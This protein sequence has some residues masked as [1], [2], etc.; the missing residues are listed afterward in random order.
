MTSADFQHNFALSATQF[1]ERCLTLMVVLGATDEQVQKVEDLLRNADDALGHPLL[2]LGLCAELLLQHMQDIVEDAVDK[3]IETTRTMRPQSLSIG[4]VPS[5]NQ[6][7]SFMDRVQRNRRRS[8]QIEDEVKLTKA[9]LTK[10]LPK[11]AVTDGNLE[12]REIDE[13]TERFYERFEYIFL[14]MDALMS[15]SKIYADEMSFNAETIRGEIS[16]REA[17]S[18]AR[19]AGASVVIAVVATFYLPITSIATIFAMPVFDFKNDW[20]DWR[21]KPVPSTKS[22]N[23]STTG[24]DRKPAEELPVFSGYFWIYAAIAIGTMFFTFFLCWMFIGGTS[25]DD[26]DGTKHPFRRHMRNI[27]DFIME[28]VPYFIESCAKNRH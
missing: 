21:Y 3:C 18:G 13:V 16:R 8:Q 23:S 5:T 6:V 28:S 19:L 25:A 17:I 24:E 26:P 20:R 10:Q 27:F 11:K 2:M 22:N 12:D 14:E 15:K 7:I 1:D 4:S 9:Y